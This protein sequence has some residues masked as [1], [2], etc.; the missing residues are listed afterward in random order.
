MRGAADGRVYLGISSAWLRLMS[1]RVHHYASFTGEAAG[2]EADERR[3]GRDGL[4]QGQVE[5][6]LASVAVRHSHF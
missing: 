4:L 2:H 5:G 3:Q 1:Q 6:R